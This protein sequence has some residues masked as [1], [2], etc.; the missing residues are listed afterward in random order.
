MKK[1]SEN[2]KKAED[3]LNVFTI[4]NPLLSK[5][6]YIETQGSL[7]DGFDLTPRVDINWSSSKQVIKVAQILGFD[8][9][10]Q[11]KKTGKDKDSVLEKHLKAQ[12]GINDEFLKIIDP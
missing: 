9:K 2:L 4:N 7:F 12:K 1:D 10:V 8:T 11:D 6:T 5:F 3:A